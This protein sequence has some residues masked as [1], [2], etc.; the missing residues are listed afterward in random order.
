MWRCY[1]LKYEA[2]SPL[3][4]GYGAQLGIVSKT[5]YYI[6]GKTM[7]GAVTAVLSRSIMESYDPALY[8]KVGEFVKNHLILSY[9]YPVKGIDFLYPNYTA[10]GLGFGSKEDNTF[11]MSKEE[12]EKEAITSYVS[13][14]LDKTSRT[15]EEG[16]L[17][18]FE[19]VSSMEYIGY[20]LTDLEKNQ[21]NAKY[22]LSIFVR[23]VS[24]EKIRV[25]IKGREV[26]LFEAIKEI[27]VGGERIYGF[28]KVG[29]KDKRE[30]KDK[31][32]LN[33]YE[34]ALDSDKPRIKAD[35]ALSHLML[36]DD[37]VEYFAKLANIRGDIEPLVWRE[38]SEK[39][40]GQKPNF[41][42][43]AL[44]PGSRFDWKEMEIGE[45]SILQPM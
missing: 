45:Y 7:W 24:D 40:A 39:G 2:K 5:R 38:W 20:L 27:Q 8:Q 10:E 31:K 30:I 29:L 37:N 32:I 28:G 16:S 42:G 14:G 17:H 21:G 4:I 43:I 11:V 23:E 15:A 19:L 6:P 3:H 33:G 44:V 34:I 22:G 25:E 1:E 13:T 41:R 26:E 9:F 12:F 35:I 36:K 18:E